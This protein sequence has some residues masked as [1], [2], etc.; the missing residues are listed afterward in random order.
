MGPLVRRRGLRGRAAPPPP[1]PSGRAGSTRLRGPPGSTST[2]AP[3]A[4][5]SPA[6]PSPAR[7]ARPGAA[8]GPSGRGRTSRSG[9]STPYRERDE[10][11]PRNLAQPESSKRIARSSAFSSRRGA[12]GSRPAS[13]GGPNRPRATAVVNARMSRPSS[14]PTTRRNSSRVAPAATATP[15]SRRNASSSWR[16]TVA[17]RRGSRVRYRARRRSV[18]HPPITTTHSTPRTSVSRKST[19]AKLPSPLPP[20]G[21]PPRRARR[22]RPSA[23]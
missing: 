13:A 3:A 23:G 1:P 16:L 6:T 22:P 17:T 21:P 18:F 5:P 9:R 20:V 2:G 7:S 14:T 15:W 12:N 10:T 11:S 4:S 19:G 8:G